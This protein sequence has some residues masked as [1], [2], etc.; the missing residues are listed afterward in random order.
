MSTACHT[1]GLTFMSL[2]GGTLSSRLNRNSGCGNSEPEKLFHA[3]QIKYW[4]QVTYKVCTV[5]LHEKHT[6]IHIIVPHHI[7]PD[8]KTTNNGK[9]L[10]LTSFTASQETLIHWVKCSYNQIPCFFLHKLHNL[11]KF[12]Q[13][14]IPCG[15]HLVQLK[16]VFQIHSYNL[17]PVI[18]VQTQLYVRTL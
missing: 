14:K 5:F 1:V 3:T 2:P 9:T 16:T 6:A 10:L 4:R 17:K 7:F 15:H 8:T 11:N 12:Q 13:P 18:I